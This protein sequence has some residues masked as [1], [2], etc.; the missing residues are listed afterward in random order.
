MRVSA[1]T[2]V[3]K[4]SPEN[5]SVASCSPGD[6]VVFETK[7]CFSNQ[8]RSE[9]KLFE[10]TDWDTVNPATGPLNIEGAEPGDTLKVKIEKLKLN[11]QGVMVVVPEMGFLDNFVKL[12]ETKI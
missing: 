7:D 8:I 1:D 2:V 12:S 9:D 3:Y 4:M 11:D 5:K 10:T 6:T